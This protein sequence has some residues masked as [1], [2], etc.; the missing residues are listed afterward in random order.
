MAAVVLYIW[1]TK[2]AHRQQQH[3]QSQ[4]GYHS[5]HIVIVIVIERTDGRTVALL[6][7]QL[8]LNCTSS[9]SSLFI[10]RQRG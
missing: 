8:K 9:S 3:Q 10:N 6:L 7:Q 1:I 5:E 2:E 4:L